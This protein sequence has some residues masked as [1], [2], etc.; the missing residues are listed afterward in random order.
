MKGIFIAELTMIYFKSMIVLNYLPKRVDRRTWLILGTAIEFISFFLVG[1]EP[2]LGLSGD[3]MSFIMIGIGICLCGFGGGLSILPILPELLDIG[4]Y[5]ITDDKEAIGDVASASNNIGFQIGE[6][7]GPLLGGF[8]G[9]LVGFGHGASIFSGI[10][11]IYLAVYFIFGRAYEA[12]SSKRRA[13]SAN[14]IFQLKNTEMS[15]YKKEYQKRLMED[16]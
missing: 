8:L 4:T 1:P 12:F 16:E 3:L 13:S 5:H 9:G 6:F 10:I 2:Y 7:L 14:I 15:Q 11:L